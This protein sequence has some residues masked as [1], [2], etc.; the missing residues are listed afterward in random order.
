MPPP[1]P[2]M[3]LALLDG[4]AQRLFIVEAYKHPKGDSSCRYWRLKL[5]ERIEVRIMRRL[6]ELE[7][8]GGF[9]RLAY[10]G[11]TEPQMREAVK[12]S[13][14]AIV[15]RWPVTTEFVMPTIPAA[16]SV[17]DQRAAD[18]AKAGVDLSSGSPLLR[19]I[20]A[21]RAD[22]VPSQIEE[23]TSPTE[24]ASLVERR[25]QMLEAY[26]AKTGA[27]N[28]KIYEAATLEFTSQSFTS[29][30]MAAFPADPP[31]ASTSNGSCGSRNFQYHASRRHNLLPW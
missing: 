13:L 16:P 27:S 4:Y 29:G 1:R 18:Y 23:A 11:V 8:S 10:H 17:T 12:N 25:A 5:V 14:A 7:S 22:D 24:T 19:M 3:I 28:R 21:A 20:M 9:R 31:P 30:G 2:Q 26:K 15:G 6:D